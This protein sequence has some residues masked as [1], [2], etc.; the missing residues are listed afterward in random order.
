MISFPLTNSVAIFLLV[1]LIMLLAPMILTRLKIPNI[2]GLI[3]AGMVVGPYGLNLLSRDASFE[4]F[5]QVGILY[6]MFLAGVEIDMYNLRKNIR[7]GVFFGL[8]TFLLPMIGGVILSRLAF[9]TGWSTAVLLS[10]MYASHTLISYPIVNRF[11]LGKSQAVV[12]SVSGT[13]VAVLL[14]LITL[15]EVVDVRTHGGFAISGIWRLAVQ[16]AVFSVAVGYLYPKLTRLFFRRYNDS[17][18][19]FIYILAMVFLAAL[20]SNLIG[21]EAILGAFY[22]GLVLNR[23]VPARSGLMT[24][25]VFVGNAIFIPYFLIGVGMLINVRVVF[26]GVGVLYVAAVMTGVALSMKWLS[27]LVTQKVLRLDALDRRMIF[28][29]SSGKAAATIAA[30]MVG[31]NY[32]LLNEEMMNGA[33]LMILVCCGVAS[34]MTERAALKLRIRLTADS[35]KTD[36]SDGTRINARQLVAV[37]NPVTAEEIMNLAILMRHS[38]NREPMTVLYVRNSDEAS[39][40]GMGRA[41]MAKAAAAAEAVDIKVREVERYDIN[42]VAGMVN[43]MKEQGSSD[44]VLGMHRK[45]SIVDTFYGTLIEQLLSSTHKMVILSRCF[46]PVDTIRRLVVAVPQKGEY[47]TG[48]RKWVERMGNL[49]T[50]LGCPLVFMASKETSRYIRGVLAAGKYQVNEQYI[51]MDGWDDFIT[52]SATVE[53]DD[54]MVIIGARRT[55]VSFSAEQENLPQFLMRYFSSQNMLMIYPE[56]FGAEEEMPVPIDVLSQRIATSPVEGRFTWG[57]IG[58]LL[59]S[60]RMMRRFVKVRRRARHARRDKSE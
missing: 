20:V 50:Q 57:R 9:D 27:A 22:A 23:F 1:L 41:A 40:V 48:F 13:I 32:G 49:A 11:G 3:V 47:E 21:L 14:A 55:S 43:V 34:V 58:E 2:V 15:A 5:G 4:I 38:D 29:L 30:T 42:I 7:G 37:A 10:T 16:T 46:V 59:R 18:A 56:Q 52:E 60:R 36:G 45:M 25:I 8:V 24:R 12:I 51:D 33:V 53:Y 26:G 19:Q 44:L 54:L 39:S 17:V 6:L 31:Y 35:L 28:G